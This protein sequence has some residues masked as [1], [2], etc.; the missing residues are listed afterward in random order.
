MFTNGLDNIRL[1]DEI[2]LNER[3][4]VSWFDKVEKTF[5]FGIFHIQD[6]PNTLSQLMPYSM[7]GFLTF[8]AQPIADHAEAAEVYQ[9]YLND[10]LA[11]NNWWEDDSHFIIPDEVKALLKQQIDEEVDNV[12]KQWDTEVTAKI[13]PNLT[14]IKTEEE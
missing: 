14:L 3:T 8:V 7:W 2:S 6:Q 1:I 11:G 4:I 9:L 5:T 12:T 13:K 10:M